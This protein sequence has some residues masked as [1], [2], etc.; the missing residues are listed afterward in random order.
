MRDIKPIYFNRGQIIFKQGDAPDGVYLINDGT[1][2]I[3]GTIVG[4]KVT[5]AQIGS[6]SIFGELAFIDRKP[7]S[8]SAR[9]VTEVRAFM[10]DAPSFE[11]KMAELDPFMKAMFRVLST[12][13]RRTNEKLMEAQSDIPPSNRK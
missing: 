1:V 13:L 3:Y 7:R 2:E 12:T 5:F 4:K 8:A 9:A 10:V 11:K 6:K